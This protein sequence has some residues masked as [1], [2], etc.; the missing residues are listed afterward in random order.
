M[1]DTPREVATRLLEGVTAGRW[2]ELADLYAEDTVVEQ[3]FSPPRPAVIRGK[4]A[5]AK[6]FAASLTQRFR[7]RAHN[8]VT[9]ETADPEVVVVEYDYEVTTA[10][11]TSTVPNI[12]VIRVRDGRIVASRDYHHHQAMLDALN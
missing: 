4:E 9:H 10:G 6:H 12:Q 7:L 1:S 5:I 3:P 2:S 11:R 8:V